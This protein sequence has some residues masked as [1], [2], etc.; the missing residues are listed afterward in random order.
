MYL[1]WGSGNGDEWHERRPPEGATVYLH[2]LKFTVLRK[3]W[4]ALM[5]TGGTFDKVLDGGGLSID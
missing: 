3:E 4:T 1:P 2:I 5:A